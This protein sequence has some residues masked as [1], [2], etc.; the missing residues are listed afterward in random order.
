MTIKYLDSKRISA[1][2]SDALVA[3]LKFNDNVTDSAGSNNGTVTGTTTYVAGKINNAFSFNGSSYITLANES[4][5]DIDYNEPF[6]IAFWYKTNNTSY[7]SIYGKGNNTSPYSGI[8]IGIYLGKIQIDQGSAYPSSYFTKDQSTAVTANVW[9]HAVMTLSGSGTNTGCKLYVDGSIVPM[10]TASPDNQS[11]SILNNISPRIGYDG[12]NYYNTGLLDDVR[13]YSRE[14][15]QSEVTMIYNSGNGTEENKPTNVQDNSILVEKDTA[16][17]YWGSNSTVKV[18]DIEDKTLVA[19]GSGIGYSGAYIDVNIPNF[20]SYTGD[21]RLRT[22]DTTITTTDFVLDFDWWRQ[23]SNN[24]PNTSAGLVLRSSQSG[25]SIENSGITSD[26][27]IRT[28][29]NDAGTTLEFLWHSAGTSTETSI[30]TIAV[31]SIQAWKYMRLTRTDATTLKFEQFSSEARTGSATLTVNYTSLPSS[32]GLGLK[33]IGGYCSDANAG[34][35]LHER[36]QNIDLSS[37]SNGTLTTWTRGHF[38]IRGIFGGGGGTVTDLM[39]YITIATTSNAIDFGDLTVARRQLAGL[40]SDTRG[41]F[42]GGSTG[43]NTD[44][45]DYVTIATLGNAT[46]FGNLT[47]RRGIAGLANDTRGVFLG[48]YAGSYSQIMDYVTIATTGNATTFGNVPYTFYHGA[49]L[50][51]DTRGVMGVAYVNG[52]T[53]ADMFYITI[54][55]TGNATSFGTLTVS[56]MHGSSVNNSTRGV[57]CTG[58]AGSSVWSNVMDYITIA[59]TGNATDFGDLSRSVEG[60]AGVSDDTRGTIAGGHT[61]A[62]TVNNI[63]YITIATLGNSTDFGDLTVA[64]QNLAGGVS[65][66]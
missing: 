62:T 18:S 29:A 13:I 24:P 5:F 33:Y 8:Q 35:G 20:A 50:A 52:S 58:Y 41:I 59:T 46:D 30:G 3:H 47:A 48:G 21:Y 55:T 26:D 4:N 28:N 63:D 49:G 38:D 60:S 65:G 9:H 16:N 45:M 31:G 42:G 1:L 15:D 44:V 43:S 2:S 56:R 22:L 39:D 36:L 66:G 37:T 6:S 32:W 54:A 17:R 14:I 27:Y 7:N 34:G 64:R 40:S 57:F 61:G 53:S 10:N 51:N 25:L 23:G 12:N 19:N 11:A